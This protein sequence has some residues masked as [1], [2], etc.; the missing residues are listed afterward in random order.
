[1]ALI[2]PTNRIATMRLISR[3]RVLDLGLPQ[4]PL[5]EGLKGAFG[6]LKEGSDGDTLTLA[7]LEKAL[8]Q[9]HLN[10]FQKVLSITPPLPGTTTPFI[11]P[12]A[13]GIP[14]VWADSIP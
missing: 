7:E 10:W 8:G 2:K 11:D 6:V 3:G 4:F 9:D 12:N 5:D 1:M 14:G 13:G